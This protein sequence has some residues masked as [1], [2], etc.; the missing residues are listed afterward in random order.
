MRILFFC[1]FYHRALLFRQQMDALNARGH[2]VR[3]FNSAQYG[4]GVEDKFKPIMDDMVRHYEC[5]NKLDRLLFFPR[6]WKIEK[7]LIEA[8][9]LTSFDL[10]HAQLM[11]SSGYSAL[12][13]KK[14]YGLPYVVSVRVTD[15]TGFIRLPYFRRMAV[16]II[17]EANGVLYLSNSH[18]DAFE[19]EILTGKER[20][21][22]EGKTAV[23]GNCLENFWS[24]HIAPGRTVAPQKKGKLRVLSV[25]KI[26]P[27]KNLTVAAQA[28][29]ALRARGYDATL[30]VIGNNQDQEEY[31]RI[32]AYGCVTIKDFM[33]HEGLL[34]AYRESDVF[35]LPSLNETFGRVYL[36]AMT[37]GLPVL[38]TAG[39]GF[40]GL[41]K[42]GEVGY[43]IP[44][45]SP[46]IIADRIESI[47]DDYCEISENCVENSRRFDE[48]SIMDQLE[49]FYRKSLYGQGCET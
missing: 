14:R 35:L 24:E 48:K 33:G 44:H 5:W 17:R 32:K 22:L 7:K 27:I 42:E 49:A 13:M 3:A 9:D 16:K 39:Q 10:L 29:E 15:L 21:L 11:L 41:F 34:E 47:L 8:Y 28:V 23:I 30:T 4:E 43:S 18:K 25:A 38:Y 1:S 20:A 45:D 19:K 6:Q 36:E 40:D 37:Q 46:E 2:Y 26:R 12:R 31:D